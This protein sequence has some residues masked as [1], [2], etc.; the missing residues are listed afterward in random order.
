MGGVKNRT[1]VGAVSRGL[2]LAAL[3]A[4]L[5]AS[6]C[7][8]SPEPPEN[9]ETERA[10]SAGAGIQAVIDPETGQ[11]T[12]DPEVIRSVLQARPP[13]PPLSSSDLL[14]TS[15]E[16]LVAVELPNGL[17]AVDLEGRF[18]APLEVV[19]QEDPEADPDDEEREDE[20]SR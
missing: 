20:D 2:G 11:L 10:A 13:R 17:V 1:S 16:G 15:D 7:A 5:A 3:A 6:G 9:A 19:I 4:V 18:M 14:S 12:S 8:S